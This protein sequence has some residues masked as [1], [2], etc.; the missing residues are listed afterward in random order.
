MK[1]Q[2]FH[3]SNFDLSCWITWLIIIILRSNILTLSLNYDAQYSIK[4]MADLSSSYLSKAGSSY[5][6]D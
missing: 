3:D 1:M 2:K 6:F 5:N 4:L